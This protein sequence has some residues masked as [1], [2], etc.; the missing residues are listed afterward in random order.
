MK[1][2]LPALRDRN[3]LPAPFDMEAEASED[4]KVPDEVVGFNLVSLHGDEW[5]EVRKH[6]SLSEPFVAVLTRWLG[7]EAVRSM[8]PAE[9]EALERGI[10]KLPQPEPETSF[11]WEAIRNPDDIPPVSEAVVN[12]RNIDPQAVVV[13]DAMAGNT[14]FR[15]YISKIDADEDVSVAGH[16]EEE[17][18][19][20]SGITAFIRNLDKLSA[21]LSSLFADVDYPVD[22][23]LVALAAGDALEKS[24]PLVSEEFALTKRPSEEELEVLDRLRRKVVAN[25]ECARKATGVFPLGFSSAALSGVRRS[26]SRKSA[27]DFVFAVEA[28]GG[29]VK[30][31]ERITDGGRAF[32]EYFAASREFADAVADFGYAPRDEAALVSHILVRRQLKSAAKSLEVKWEDVGHLFFVNPDITKATFKRHVAALRVPGL[33]GKLSSVCGDRSSTLSEVREA[34][35]RNT[36]Q[37]EFRLEAG[38]RVCEAVP[39]ITVGRLKQFI[40]VEPLIDEARATLLKFGVSTRDEVEVLERHLEWMISAYA[41]PV[42]DEA[43]E[44]IIATRGKVL[45]GAGNSALQP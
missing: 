33:S 5:P 9:A 25:A 24:L 17:R 14:H 20:L 26:I 7:D 19:V 44:K 22:A 12:Y 31:R 42:P 36:V 10:A 4:L 15:R 34:A 23:A 32:M 28:L 1:S 41:L 38:T 16:I 43:I 35:Y 30:G 37:R 18:K 8:T 3:H 6:G 11:V 27:G 39:D 40:E 2:N 13:S 21:A 29:S 45:D